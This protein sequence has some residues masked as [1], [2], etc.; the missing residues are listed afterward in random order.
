MRLREVHIYRATKLFDSAVILTSEVAESAESALDDQRQGIQR[1][2]ALHLFERLVR[3]PHRGQEEC[4]PM[5]RGRVVGVE[6]NAT[7]KFLLSSRPIP[8]EPKALEGQPPR[9]WGAALHERES[10]A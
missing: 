4:V 3:P 5:V 9:K 6:L 8:I 2:G 1:L 10:A 7:L